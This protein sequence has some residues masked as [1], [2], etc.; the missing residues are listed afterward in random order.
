MGTCA[1]KKPQYLGPLAGFKDLASHAAS[2][3]SACSHACRKPDKADALSTPS[4]ATPA[5]TRKLINAPSVRH[6]EC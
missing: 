6:D 1:E 3:K 2:P 4:E 5:E